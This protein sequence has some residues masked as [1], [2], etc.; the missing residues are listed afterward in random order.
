MHTAQNIFWSRTVAW[1]ISVA[2]L[3]S[4]VSPA[5]YAQT[6]GTPN[7]QPAEEPPE[8]V[9]DNEEQDEPT[10][11]GDEENEEQETPT[12]SLSG[13]TILSLIHI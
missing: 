5:A 8:R 13:L 10:G 9:S 2:M 1:C 7:Q 4:A 3:F 6:Q 12:V 11:S